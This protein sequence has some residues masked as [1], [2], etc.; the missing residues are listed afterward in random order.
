MIWGGSKRWPNSRADILAGLKS[1]GAKPLGSLSYGTID[2]INSR[3]YEQGRWKYVY[4]HGNFGP[5]RKR[6]YLYH[7]GKE[8]VPPTAKEHLGDYYVTPW[9]KLWLVPVSKMFGGGICFMPWSYGGKEGEQLVPPGLD[10]KPKWG[11]A[12]DG[13]QLGLDLKGRE[14]T[15]KDVMV[16]TCH[17]RNVSKDKE[18]IIRGLQ[19]QACGLLLTPESGGKP[20]YPN[21]TIDAEIGHVLRTTKLKA[22]ENTSI[23]IEIKYGEW[24]FRHP[25]HGYIDWPPPGRYTVVAQLSDDERKLASGGI[26]IAV[27]DEAKRLARMVAKKHLGLVESMREIQSPRMKRYLSDHRFFRARAPHP[28]AGILASPAPNVLTEVHGGKASVV[29]AP[30]KLISAVGISVED[31]STAKDIAL[32]YA[33]LSNYKLRTMPYRG[34]KPSRDWAFDVSKNDGVWL[35]TYVLE[36]ELGLHISHRYRITVTQDGK[37]AADRFKKVEQVYGGYR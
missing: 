32:M 14:F 7:D 4:T 36:T 25:K 15:K 23:Q 29:T 31:A 18:K 17:A 19:R 5:S 30:A 20:I 33:E 26:E 22:G 11:E 8:L 9:G 6:S 2:V 12:V 10:S 35:V 24:E 28:A 27:K 13:I 34:K 21:A 16:F 1:D 3:T 37:V